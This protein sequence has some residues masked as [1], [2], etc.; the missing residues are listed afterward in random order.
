MIVGYV[1]E[2]GR[3]IDN[4]WNYVKMFELLGDHMVNGAIV[5]Q[6]YFWINR[7]GT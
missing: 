2:R 7:K 6:D 3:I 5:M 1:S 4:D